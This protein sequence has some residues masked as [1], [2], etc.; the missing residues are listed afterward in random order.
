MTGT[1]PIRCVHERVELVSA[2][3][4]IGFCQDCGS[5]VYRC[6]DEFGEYAEWLAPDQTHDDLREAYAQETPR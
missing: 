2:W 1:N 4:L 3:R 6:Y 5:N